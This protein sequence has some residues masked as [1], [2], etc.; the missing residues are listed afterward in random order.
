MNIKEHIDL[1][2]S[3][4]PVPLSQSEALQDCLA[5]IVTLL[6]API[7]VNPSK[8]NE[9]F[10]SMIRDAIQLEVEEFYEEYQSDMQFEMTQQESDEAAGFK[11]GE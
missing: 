5:S 1:Y 2:N 10:G 9:T 11:R 8:L 4:S 7:S 3:E 6:S